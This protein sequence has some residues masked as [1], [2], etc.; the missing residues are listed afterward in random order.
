MWIAAISVVA[1]VV[2]LVIVFVLKGQSGGQASSKPS[3]GPEQKDTEFIQRL[4]YL[5]KIVMEHSS[6][7]RRESSTREVIR[8][9]ESIHEQGGFRYMIKIHE[10][11]TKETSPKVGGR[12]KVIWKGIGD[13]RA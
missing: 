9:G 11:V 13:W 4:S 10:A 7:D 8:I 12:L 1:G 3:K 2:I 6:A 5:M